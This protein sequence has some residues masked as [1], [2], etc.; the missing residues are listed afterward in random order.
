[1]KMHL[2]R[3]KL[4]T[5]SKKR[6]RYAPEG[7]TRKRADTYCMYGAKGYYAWQDRSG[8][9]AEEWNKF[10]DDLAK[11]RKQEKKTHKKMLREA[12]ITLEEI[13]A[14]QELMKDIQ[15]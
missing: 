1:M 9:R 5:K 4:I 10:W 15:T 12:E 14:A 13:H 11:S 7:P 8:D 6:R 3:R 2:M